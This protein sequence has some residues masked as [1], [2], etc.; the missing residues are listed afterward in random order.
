MYNI[1]GG[2]ALMNISREKNLI[3]CSICNFLAYSMPLN[4]MHFSASSSCKKRFLKQ[5]MQD[6]QLFYTSCIAHSVNRTSRVYKLQLSLPWEQCSTKKLHHCQN[7]TENCFPCQRM[8]IS[9]TSDQ[10]ARKLSHI[11]TNWSLDEL[12]SDSKQLYLKARQ[13]DQ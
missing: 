6:Q 8:T 13:N 12:I 3:L 5:R 2:V 9:T 11:N 4:F 7:D 1:K 10:R